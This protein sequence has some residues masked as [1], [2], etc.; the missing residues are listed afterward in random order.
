MSRSIRRAISALI[1]GS[2]ATG[3]ALMSILFEI[4][5]DDKGLADISDVALLIACGTGA[6]VALKEIQAALANAREG[7]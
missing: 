5:A 4:Q 7:A 1:N 6:M 3:G 2:I